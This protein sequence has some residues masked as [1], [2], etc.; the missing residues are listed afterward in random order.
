MNY[1]AY[2][3]PIPIDN[4][5]IIT[6]QLFRLGIDSLEE[7]EDKLI[8][9]LAYKEEKE[10][11]NF[12]NELSALNI[13]FSETEFIPYKNWN[14]EWEKNFEPIFINETIAVRASFHPISN[15]PIEIIINPKMSF[16]T[17]HHDTTSQMMTQ[18]LN[19]DF[20]NKSVMDFGSGTGILSILA[21]K[22][23]AYIIVALDNEEWAYYNEM[24]NVALNNCT[25][26]TLLYT[27][28]LPSAKYDIILANINR[29]V[30]LQ[31][32]PLLVANCKKDTLLLT[33]GYYL[34]DTNIIQN[35]TMQYGFKL[36]Y[37]QSLHNWACQLYRFV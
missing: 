7:L 18:M 13:H 35:E 27:D 25:N 20:T 16:G 2:H 14:E 6:A 28:Q 9:Y 12:E 30:I 26:I 15:F 8:A 4:V 23:G 10:F 36:L 31:Y 24:E 37:S 3:I 33:S 19:I 5:D 29:N 17:G 22:L 32:L 1:K 11:L 21:S 34:E